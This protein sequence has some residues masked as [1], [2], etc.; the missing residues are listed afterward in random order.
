MST[1]NGAKLLQVEILEARPN[2]MFTEW[3]RATV[4]FLRYSKPIR[5][6]ECGKRTKHHW[7]SLFAFQAL[8]ASGASFTLKSRSGK[9]HQ[10]LTPVCRNH[11]MSPDPAAVEK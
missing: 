1:I 7:T 4:R 5:C 2:K 8:D 6:A 11:P 10:P 3:Q 9:L